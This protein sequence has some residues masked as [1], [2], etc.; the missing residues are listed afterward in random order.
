MNRREF[1]KGAAASAMTACAWL[2]AG[3][4]NRNVKPQGETASDKETPMKLA[5]CGIDCNTC[6]L[7]RR[8]ATVVTPKAT[9]S[10]AATARSASAACS[11]RS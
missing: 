1:L 11:T 5:P 10:G 6:K 4:D 3:C 2:A 7:C 9:T 8:T